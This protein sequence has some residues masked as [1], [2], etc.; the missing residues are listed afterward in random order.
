MRKSKTTIA[1]AKAN[2]ERVYETTTLQYF[3][4]CVDSSGIGFFR[5]LYWLRKDHADYVN[6]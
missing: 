2:Y 5:V 6:K 1:E 3:K 4:Q